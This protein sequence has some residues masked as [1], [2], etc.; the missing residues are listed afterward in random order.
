MTFQETLARWVIENNRDKCERISTNE[1]RR[2]SASSKPLQ[3]MKE[4]RAGLAEW[5]NG[6]VNQDETDGRLENDL[7]SYFEQLVLRGT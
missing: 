1:Y 6:I 7:K 5:A 3:K 4:C 2:S